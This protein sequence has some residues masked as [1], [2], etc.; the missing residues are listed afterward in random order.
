MSRA[1]ESPVPARPCRLRFAIAESNAI[2]VGQLAC[3]NRSPWTVKI[4][5]NAPMLGSERRPDCVVGA[6]CRRQSVA[7]LKKRDCSTDVALDEPSP[8][9]R[10]ITRS[11]TGHSFFRRTRRIQ[12]PTREGLDVGI[13]RRTPASAARGDAGRDR[14]GRSRRPHRARQFAGR[15][16]FRLRAACPDRLPGRA[17]AARSLSRRRI[18]V[19]AS[20]FFAAAAH[21]HDGRRTRALRATPR[22][23]RISCRNQPESDPDRRIHPRDQRGARRQRPSPG[24][25]QVPRPA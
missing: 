2:A 9:R 19:I 7:I 14:R 18:P 1:G 25:G 3:L 8:E 23:R 17:A 11:W 16:P 13:D 20:K 10:R 6:R 21:A 5:A 12:L 24:R 15:E 22:W 4:V